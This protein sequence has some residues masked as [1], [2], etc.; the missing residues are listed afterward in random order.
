MSRRTRQQLVEI[1]R[2][3][4]VVVAADEQ[5]GCPVHALRPVAGEEDDGKPLAVLCAQL[6][7]DRVA[8]RVR[9]VDVKQ[10][11]VR[12]LRLLERLPTVFGLDRL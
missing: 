3:D 4:D 8:A 6:P 2:L 5:P 10:H 9:E 11:H 12:V 7:A 1:R